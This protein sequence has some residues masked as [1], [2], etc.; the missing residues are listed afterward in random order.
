MGPSPALYIV[1]TPLITQALISFLRQHFPH[2]HPLDPTGATLPPF[3]PYACLLVE[4]HLPDHRC[5]LHWA[6]S[7]HRQYPH[8]HLI[9][10]T[11]HPS[12]FHLWLAYQWGFPAFLDKAMPAA[13]LLYHLR[14]L[15]QGQATWP[16]PL[17]QR[18]VEWGQ[19]VA[20]V[21]TGLSVDLWRV[22][23]G[24][25]R[26][27]EVEVLSRRLGLSE[28]TVRRKRKELLEALSAQGWAEAVHKACEWGLVEVNN[29]RLAF[30]S[31]VWEVFVEQR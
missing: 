6:H 30:R 26:G 10:W 8:L 28:G 11:T 13:E 21:L 31:V 7:L 17:F 22:W 5:G 29:G 15:L 3:L 23:E 2:V 14:L 12:S 16:R 1:D 9:P 19:R 24:L 4:V 20:P 18:A 25:L 27:E